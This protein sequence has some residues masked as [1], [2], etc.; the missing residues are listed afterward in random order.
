MTLSNQAKWTSCPKCG[1]NISLHSPAEK[2]MGQGKKMLI[3]DDE[4]GIRELLVAAFEG[5]GF[6]ITTAKTGEEALHLFHQQRPD[7]VLLDIKLPDLDG[8]EVLQRIK[9]SVAST[10]VI[11]I[12][13]V[14]ASH[15]SL[16]CMKLGASAYI[17]KPF[18]LNYVTMVVENASKK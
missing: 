17:T 16:K 6:E 15:I 4:A 18:D 11:M 3:V 10:V 1:E 7:V 9:Q 13:A 8:T 12:T 5:T 2:A 14:E